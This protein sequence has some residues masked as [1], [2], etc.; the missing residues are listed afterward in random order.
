MFTFKTRLS[1]IALVLL[2]IP[3][4]AVRIRFTSVRL[5]SKMILA[6]I[7]CRS[8]LNYQPLVWSGRWPKCPENESSWNWLVSTSE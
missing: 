1:V 7:G 8:A 4:Q 2:C 3:S 5:R 6:R